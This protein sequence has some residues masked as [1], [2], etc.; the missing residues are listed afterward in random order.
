MYAILLLVSTKRFIN[1][2]VL[3]NL[4]WERDGVEKNVGLKNIVF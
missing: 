1:Y 3:Y 4:K 2:G